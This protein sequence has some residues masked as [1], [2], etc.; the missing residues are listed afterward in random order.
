MQVVAYA[1]QHDRAL[2]DVTLDALAH[3]EE[4]L[5]GKGGPPSRRGTLKSEGAGP[6]PPEPVGGGV[7][8]RQN[9]PDLISKEKDG[10][11]QQHGRPRR[12]RPDDKR[13]ACS[14]A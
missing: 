7:G 8:E 6:A 9:G 1:R 3:V 2:L 14:T 5:G 4:G 12:H 11:D 10:D 13:C